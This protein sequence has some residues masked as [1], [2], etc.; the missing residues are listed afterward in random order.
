GENQHVEW[1]DGEVIPMPPVGDTH[2]DF[3]GWLLA[4]LRVY[5]DA[6]QL[7]AVRYEP[8]QMKTGPNLPGRAP[9]IFFVSKKNLSRLKKNH[10]QGPADV[11]IEIISPGSTA[12]D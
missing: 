9:D 4:L 5:V 3:G 8:F 1:V 12:V 10:L 7:G 2:Q 11:V 6:G